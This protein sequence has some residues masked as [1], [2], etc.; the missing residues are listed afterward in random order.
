[1]VKRLLRVVGISIQRYLGRIRYFPSISNGESI[2]LGRVI[3]SF[4]GDA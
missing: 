4:L 2:R 1:M 3:G